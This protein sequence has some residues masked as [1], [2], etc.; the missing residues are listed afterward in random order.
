MITEFTSLL[1]RN[2]NYRY[3]WMGQIVSEVG[4][5]FNNIAVFDLVLRGGRPHSGLLVAGIMLARGVSMI[6]AGPLAGVVLDR[7]DRKRVMIASDL[8]RAALA[9]A[10]IIT[11][12][13]PDPWVLYVLS[14][15]LMFASPF[16]PAAGPPFFP[17]SP[18]A[19]NCTPPTRSRRRRSG[20]R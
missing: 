14:A 5:H 1:R 10:F 18:A 9:A 4:D 12:K 8:I 15:L 13:N 17:Q 7:L 3:T 20:P 6:L 2:R 16:S 11:V 19:K